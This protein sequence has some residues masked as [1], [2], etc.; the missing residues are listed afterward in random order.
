[1][2]VDE[3]FK[4]IKD[5]HKRFWNKDRLSQATAIGMTPE[6]VSTLAS[7]VEEETNN[8]EEK[9]MVAGL[10]TV[11]YTHL[12]H[13]RFTLSAIIPATGLIKPCLLYTSRCV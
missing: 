11:S 7:I 10:Y 1:M 3:F 4:R 13:L 5:E 2:S 9:A 12:N 6:E 8:N